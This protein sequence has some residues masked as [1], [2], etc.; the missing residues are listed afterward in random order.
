MSR[1]QNASW[2]AGTITP[3]YRYSTASRRRRRRDIV[4]WL[5]TALMAKAAKTWDTTNAFALISGRM[6]PRTVA[7]ALLL[8]RALRY[9]FYAAPHTP[10]SRLLLYFIFPVGV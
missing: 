4:A 5:P 1:V 9:A 7:G 8:L 2:H 3:P 6:L 10:F